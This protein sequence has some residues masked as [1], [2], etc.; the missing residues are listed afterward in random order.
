M[1][2]SAA[3]IYVF[4]ATDGYVTD[5]SRTVNFGV[6]GGNIV[7]YP[8]SHDF[9]GGDVIDAGWDAI[10]DME[11]RDRNTGI[12]ELAGIVFIASGAAT[13]Y[14]RVNLGAGNYRIWLALGDRTGYTSNLAATIKDGVGGSTLFSVADTS[15]GADSFID[16]DSVE[17]TATNFLAGQGSQDITLT[18]ADLIVELP[19]SANSNRISYLKI[20]SIA[21][22][23]GAAPPA[24]GCII[25]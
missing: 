7:T 13:R 4:R 20:E 25:I 5:G 22:G 12:P 24:G 1:S 10:T 23:G 3:I 2:L 16:A 9:G 8:A 17:F 18:S 11:G 21:G 14:F 19:S 6:S 15:I